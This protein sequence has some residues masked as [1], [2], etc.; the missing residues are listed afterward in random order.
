MLKIAT[1]NVNSLRV[2]LP[3]LL[4]WLTLQQPDILALQETKIQDQH[5]PLLE[6][7]AAG[8]H[9]LFSGQKTYNGVALL[10]RYPG[11]DLLTDLP[12]YP[13]EQRRVVAATYEDQL[14]IVN[15]YVPNGAS[16]GS[17]KYE[18]KLTW[19][20]QLSQ[21][22]QA[23]LIRYPRLMVLGDFNIAPTDQDIYDPA[24]WEEA[25]L[26]SPLER[27]ALQEILALGLHDTFRLVDSPLNTFSWWDYRAA[28]FKRNHG[29]RIDLILASTALVSSVTSCIIDSI[30]RGW[31]R[32]SDHAP[33]VAGVQIN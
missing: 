8:Y 15:V 5:F 7:Q 10:S 3:Q 26:V 13:D 29:A 9:A 31:E 21:Y 32:P 30:P 16:V 24:N 4:Q 17:A 19:L 20:K 12:N 6:I 18:Y 23:T 11:F 25:V 28:A 33:V 22:L 14:R 1:W 2:R 27:A